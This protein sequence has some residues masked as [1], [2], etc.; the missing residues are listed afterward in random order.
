MLQFLSRRWW[1]VMG[2]GYL[3]S[4]GLAVGM[5]WLLLGSSI[6]HHWTFERS[7]QIKG[8]TDDF[9]SLVIKH[10]NSEATEYL[11][12]N[13]K[14]GAKSSHQL[15]HLPD[16]FPID[17]FKSR[18]T[19]LLCTV[20]NPETSRDKVTISLMTNGAILD[21]VQS[22]AEGLSTWVNDWA[23]SSYFGDLK[24]IIQSTESDP[25]RLDTLLRGLQEREKICEYSY[26]LSVKGQGVCSTDG[27]W[28]IL[29]KKH[30]SLIQSWAAWLK[31]KFQWKV[32]TS[33]IGLSYSALIIDLSTREQITCPL[34]I[35][36]Q[37]TFVIHPKGVGF[38]VLQES[39]TSKIASLSTIDWYTL[40]LGPAYHTF[41]QWCLILAAFGVPVAL[42]MFWNLLCRKRRQLVAVPPHP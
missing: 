8:F 4:L 10:E 40:P 27:R 42:L 32:N 13:L 9:E 38:A 23:K 20:H 30:D 41:Q 15:N 16:Y 24:R 26:P 2:W 6:V 39:D 1:G 37:P 33:R 35:H 11:H 34:S 22:S 12:L 7:V 25:K 3:L 29:T 21:T 36:T 17:E 19:S 28:L 31:K 14:T 18:F 5:Y